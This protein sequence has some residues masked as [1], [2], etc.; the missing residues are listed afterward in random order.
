M[1]MNRAELEFYPF[2]SEVHAVGISS[3]WSGFCTPACQVTDVRYRELSENN[4]A[5]VLYEAIPAVR[6][7]YPHR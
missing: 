2:N 7:C 3:N 1:H 5:I 4:I 6:Q